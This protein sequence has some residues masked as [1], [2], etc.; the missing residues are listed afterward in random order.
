MNMMKWTL[1]IML[2]TLTGVARADLEYVDLDYSKEVLGNPRVMGKEIIGGL[3]AVPEVIGRLPNP[4]S[5]FHSGRYALPRAGL[6]CTYVNSAGTRCEAIPERFYQN[7]ELV[8]AYLELLEEWTTT[9]YDV[10]Y[11]TSDLSTGKCL[12][13]Q[14]WLIGVTETVP[15]LCGPD[16]TTDSKKKRNKEIARERESKGGKPSKP[17]TNNSAVVH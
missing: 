11:L 13:T 15:L 5:Q 1:V 8:P 9:R 16:T 2:M 10:D 17:A 6:L 7:F 14:P 4:A 12:T 3:Y